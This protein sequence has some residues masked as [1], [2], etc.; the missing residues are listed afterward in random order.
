ME[1]VFENLKHVEKGTL[2]AK[3]SGPDFVMPIDGCT[4]MHNG[5]PHPDDPKNEALFITE[6]EKAW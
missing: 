6:P 1:G 4:I 5:K 2:I 3:G